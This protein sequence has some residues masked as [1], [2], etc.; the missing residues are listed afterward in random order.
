MGELQITNLPIILLFILIIVIT[1]FGYLEL[2]KIDNKIN[3]I[4][5]KIEIINNKFEEKYYQINQI[6]QNNLTKNNEEINYQETINNNENNLYEEK[7]IDKRLDDNTIFYDNN[8]SNS[9]D[10]NE[11]VDNI[12]NDEIIDN[13]EIIEDDEIIVDDEEIIEDEDII[14]D[15]EDNISHTTEMT[16]EADNEYKHYSVKELK[17]LCEE[18]DLK[19]SGNKS[20]L[21]SRLLNN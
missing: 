15:N 4:T 11:I 19:V 10:N 6:N 17:K 9:F 18:R 13:E 1:V 21:I 14:E 5:N 20:T 16:L 2:K 12:I 7:I 8:V 3:N